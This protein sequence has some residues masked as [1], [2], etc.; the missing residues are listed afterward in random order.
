[1]SAPD[2]ETMVAPT[3]NKGKPAPKRVWTKD[4]KERQDF[5]RSASPNSRKQCAAIVGRDNQRLFRA[6]YNE[7]QR[8]KAVLRKCT[9]LLNEKKEKIRQLQL[10]GGHHDG[11]SDHDQLNLF[12]LGGGG[13]AG[14]SLA[15]M[16]V[17]KKRRKR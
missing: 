16:A 2:I 6:Q 4:D 9:G 3:A 1:M 5:Y 10:S 17:V 8:M 12:L 15:G 11:Q 13:G 7:E 14:D